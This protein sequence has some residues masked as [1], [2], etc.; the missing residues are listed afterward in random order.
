MLFAYTAPRYANFIPCISNISMHVLVVTW[1]TSHVFKY[2]KQRKIEEYRYDMLKHKVDRLLDP[3]RTP[4][5]RHGRIRRNPMS[6]R[7]CF[8][9]IKKKWNADGRWGRKFLKLFNFKINY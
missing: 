1:M 5:S 7:R 4:T 9:F 8:S 3:Q 2:R 6:G